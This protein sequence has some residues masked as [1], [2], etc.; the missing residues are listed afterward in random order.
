ML[1]KGGD[2]RLSLPQ[3]YGRVSRTS[4]HCQGGALQS[5]ALCCGYFEPAQLNL[6]STCRE[7][8][9]VCGN[10]FPSLSVCHCQWPHLKASSGKPAAWSAGQQAAMRRLLH[11]Q[12]GALMFVLPQPPFSI[13]SAFMFVLYFP[14]HTL[15]CRA[16]I[17]YSVHCVE[18]LFCS[19]RARPAYTLAPALNGTR[20][21]CRPPRAWKLQVLHACVRA[22]RQPSAPIHRTSVFATFGLCQILLSR[23]A[24]L[25][26]D[27]W[28]PARD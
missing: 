27:A 25:H 7:V 9:L 3:L 26:S 18:T 21:A 23:H 28:Q 24:C 22:A 20:A 2:S 6:T 4:L 8:K 10:I 17:L 12:L 15:L 5:C 11:N 13:P 16:T 14:G 19:S 1:C